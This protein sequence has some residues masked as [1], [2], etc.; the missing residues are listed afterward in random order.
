MTTERSSRRLVGALALTLFTSPLSAADA[1]PSVSIR[2]P[3]TLAPGEHASIPV[4][5]SLD[6]ASAPFPL[7]LTPR[8]EGTAVELVRGRF[9]RADAKAVDATHLRFDVPVVARGLGT[10]IMRVELMTY[11]CDPEC[12]ALTVQDSRVLHVR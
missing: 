1:A 5:V 11:A 9:L 6:A 2:G 12:R 8:V 7:T 10:G 3:D 4:L